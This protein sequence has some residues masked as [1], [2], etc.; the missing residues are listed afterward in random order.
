MKTNV[1]PLMDVKEVSSYLHLS[2]ATVYSKRTRGE[3]PKGSTVKLFGKLLFV[4]E[5]IEQ[6][7]ED[8][9]E[10]SFGHS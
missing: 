8:S 3:F 7:V 2:P 9:I 6:L 4:R 10:P 5:K 1:S